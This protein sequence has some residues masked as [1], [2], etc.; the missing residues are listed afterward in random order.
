MDRPEVSKDIYE[1]LCYSKRGKIAKF[2]DER[3]KGIY[4]ILKIL[5]DGAGEVTAG[6]LAERLE[7]S[8]PRIAVALQTLENKGFIKKNKSAK[9]GR[10]TIVTITE[11]GVSVFKDK[12]NQVIKKLER[13]LTKLTDDEL[14]SLK[15]ILQ[16]LIS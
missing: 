3:L 5:S 4:I 7:V 11:L 10:K 1:L 8:T 9:D 2:S 13:Y 15:N 14:C 12:E 16:K 6:D